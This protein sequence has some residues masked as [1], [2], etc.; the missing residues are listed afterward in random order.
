MELKQK[1]FGIFSP[2]FYLIF[3]LAYLTLK[4]F[5]NKIDEIMGRISKKFK[6]FQN[7]SESF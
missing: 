1:Y 3:A 7:F 2:K 6:I 4:K 5:L